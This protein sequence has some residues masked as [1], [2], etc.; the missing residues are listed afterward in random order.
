MP[1]KTINSWED[2]KRVFIQHFQGT[3]KRPKSITDL[4]RC[5]QAK[6]ESSRE[7]VSRWSAVT[8]ACEGVSE[9]Q[10]I[11]AFKQSVKKGTHFRFMVFS[12]QSTTLVGLLA[13][14]NKYA[15][16]D[17]DNREDLDSRRKRQ[18]S[19]KSGD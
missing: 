8:N 5:V 13:C 19:K 4:L 18:P 6:N 10:A 17:D 16:A 12:D 14:A 15:A 7:F 11:H 1:E 3:Y 2:M 9:T